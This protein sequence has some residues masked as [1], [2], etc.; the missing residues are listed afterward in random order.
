MVVDQNLMLAQFAKVRNGGV[1]RYDRDLVRRTMEAMER[2]E[3]VRARRERVF[4]RRRLGGKKQREERRARDRR[5]VVEGEHLIAREMQEMERQ[6]IEGGLAEVVQ[7]QAQT[8]VLGEERMRQKAK[9]RM[10]VDGGT[11]M[12]LD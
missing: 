3:E 6:K 8:T 7:E 11:E 5:T 10:L 1:V 12:E 4:A 9:R 2:V